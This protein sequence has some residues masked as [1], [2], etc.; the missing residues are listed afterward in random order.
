MRIDVSVTGRLTNIA[1]CG[2]ESVDDNNNVTDSRGPAT[3]E[4]LLDSL[5]LDMHDKFASAFATAVGVV[6]RTPSME[7][8]ATE[9]ALCC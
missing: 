6:S 9:A 2:L 4:E 3:A 1:I 5:A 8:V 7:T